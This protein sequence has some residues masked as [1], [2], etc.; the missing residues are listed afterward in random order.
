MLITSDRRWQGHGVGT[1]NRPALGGLFGGQSA[2][3]SN[4]LSLSVIFSVATTS[5]SSLRFLSPYLWRKEQILN[6]LNNHSRPHMRYS[7][8]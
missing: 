3:G 5:A 4:G 1:R 8:H 6:N 2:L 7:M